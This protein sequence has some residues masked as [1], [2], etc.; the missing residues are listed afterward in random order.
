MNR[1]APRGRRALASGLAL[2]P[3]GGAARWKQQVGAL[4]GAA[5]VLW[6]GV[7]QAAEPASLDVGRKLFQAGAQPACAVCHTLKDAGSEGAV[8]P[9]LD[10]LRPD[11]QRVA[12]ALRNGLGSMPSYKA[13]LTEEQI[14]TLA[15]YVSSVAGR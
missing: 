9:V 15:R 5:A 6:A 11:E 14:A 3:R 12:T 8:G 13:L 7:A 4:A 2:G 1:P 10:E